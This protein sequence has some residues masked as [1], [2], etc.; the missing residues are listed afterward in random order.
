MVCATNIPSASCHGDSGS[1]LVY[2]Q[3]DKARWELFGVVSWTDDNP[4]CQVFYH[5]TVYVRVTETLDWIAR[6]ID[7][8]S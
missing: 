2:Y 5:P 4:S 1:P 8:H 7:Q 6:T 3:K